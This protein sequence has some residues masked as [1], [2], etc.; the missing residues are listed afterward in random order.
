M[1]QI[2][3]RGVGVILNSSYQ[4]T[5]AVSPSREISGFNMHEFNVIDNGARALLIMSVPG[6]VSGVHLDNGMTSL[7]AADNGFQEIDVKTGEVLFEWR[8]LDYLSVTESTTSLP[9]TAHSADQS[10]DWL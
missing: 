5:G 10:W 1:D 2:D 9:A 3:R 4:L 6:F 7:W 8:P